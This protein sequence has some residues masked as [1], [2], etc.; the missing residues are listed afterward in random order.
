MLMED[1]VFCVAFSRDSEML[2]SGSH[3]D[4]I[5]VCTSCTTTNQ[6]KHNPK[7]KLKRLQENFLW[8]TYVGME[9]TN[10]TMPTKI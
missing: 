6:T 10:W 4:K 7:I 2:V 1:S 5:K 9:S 8:S 3:D